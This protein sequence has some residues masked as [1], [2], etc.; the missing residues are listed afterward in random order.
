M[1]ALLEQHELLELALHQLGHRNAGPGGDDLGDVL[2]VDLLLQHPHLALQD[3]EAVLLGLELLRE[4]R[5]VAVGELGGTLQIAVALRALG[6]GA[7]LLDGLLETLDRLDAALLLV[8]V[9]AQAGDLLAHELEL[10]GER[11]TALGGG[12]VALLRER[13][14]LDLEAL[15]AA[16]QHVELVRHRVDLDAQAARGLVHQVDRLVGQEAVRDVAM[17]EGRGGDQRGVLDAHAVVHLVALLEPAQDRDGVGHRRLAHVDGLEAPLERGV[18]LDAGAVLVERRRADGAQLAAR[19]HRLQQVGRVDGAL[20]LAGADDRVQL[21]DEE[22]HLAVGRRDVA[23]HGLQALLELAAV[24]GAG[25]Q[26]AEIE[27]PHALA[28]EAL[29]DVARDDA[30]GEALD[31]RR[32]AD[33][34]LADQD[35]VVLRAAREHLDDAAHLVVTADHR[36]ELAGLGERRQVAP[37]LRERAVALLGVGGRGRLAAAQVAQGREQRGL[38]DA[39]ARER[40]AHGAG[41][42]GEA[43]QQVLGRGEAVAERA[44]LADRPLEHAAEAE[45]RGGRVDRLAADAR[46]LLERLLAGAADARRVGLARAQEDVRDRV[47]LVGRA[48]AAGGGWWSRDCRPPARAPARLRW[49]PEP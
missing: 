32:L 13:V 18:L 30:L 15:R 21:V 11:G 5:S 1:Q 23:E 19:E 38:G 8:P 4:R 20:G 31:D 36:V 29:G 10:L 39:G 34:R 12:R 9:R 25:E 45:R 7:R 40:L 41:R 35:R 42:L 44:R 3:G 24:L 16:D 47:A 48:R 49:P 26:R 6:G 14:V 46:Q 43:E 2:G 28:L 27:R 33:A 37:V 22:D 17:R